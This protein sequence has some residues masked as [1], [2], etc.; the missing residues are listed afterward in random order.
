M[1]TPATVPDLA[2]RRTTRRPILVGLVLLALAAASAAGWMALKNRSGTPAPSAQPAAEPT[3][4]AATPASPAPAPPPPPAAAP[5]ANESVVTTS[6]R[7]WVRVIADG[8]RVVEREL[9]AESRIAFTAEQ[10]IVIRTGD[11]GAVQL[12]IRGQAPVALG[13]DGEVVTRSFPV[14]ANRPR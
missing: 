6:R 11:A 10:T 13:R 1:A 5:A 9:P 3:A 14:D 2:T 8:A 4:P 12:S 7:A